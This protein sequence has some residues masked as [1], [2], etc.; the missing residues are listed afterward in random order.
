MPLEKPESPSARRAKAALIGAATDVVIADGVEA[1]T[2]REVAERAGYSVASLYN[3]IDGIPGLL[4]GARQS[5]EGSLAATLA[6]PE[7][8]A[9]QTA[10]ELAAVFVNYASYFCERPH[11]F[12]LL[13]GSSAVARAAGRGPAVRAG[14]AELRAL[15]GPTFS[16][17]VAAGELAPDRV[18]QTALRL[19]YLV[20]GALLIAV[21]S[22]AV[23]GADVPEQVR[24][25]VI[26]A[27][28]A[29]S[30]HTRSQST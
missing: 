24:E 8:D 22:A 12:D 9:P 21:S 1:L 18:E 11:A 5:I 13:F 6:S 27:L 28:A 16:G 2:V 17:L 29:E 10:D 7:A 25:A 23:D 30:T 26:W 14:E 20:H 3:H 19:I 4:A 15:W